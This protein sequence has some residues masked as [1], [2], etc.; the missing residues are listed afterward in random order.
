ML[1][2]EYRRNLESKGLSRD[3]L[4]LSYSFPSNKNY[5]IAAIENSR[6]TSLR[7]LSSSRSSFEGQQTNKDLSISH[8]SYS[9]YYNGYEITEEEGDRVEL[10]EVIF[11]EPNTEEI[12][13]VNVE[14]SHYGHIE[15]DGK[16]KVDIG[17]SKNAKAKIEFG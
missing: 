12:V 17:I 9:N 13:E 5:T 6:D 1:Y 11:V 4:D 8:S 2:E 3:N 16:K 15:A 7:L 10:E 14:C